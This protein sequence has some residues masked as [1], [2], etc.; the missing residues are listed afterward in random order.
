MLEPA[1]GLGSGISGGLDMPAASIA[2]RVPRRTAAL[3]IDPRRGTSV[4]LHLSRQ[5]RAGKHCL[6]LGCSAKRLGR[7]KDK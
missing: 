1:N 6:V 2:R 5:N 4:D 3:P 7:V